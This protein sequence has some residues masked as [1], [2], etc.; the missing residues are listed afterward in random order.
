MVSFLQ[1]ADGKKDT[2]FGAAG[3]NFGPF[4]FV[5]ALNSKPVFS[6]YIKNFRLEINGLFFLGLILLMKEA[7]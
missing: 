6:F 1:L 7:K 5:T 4:Y 2:I 3:K